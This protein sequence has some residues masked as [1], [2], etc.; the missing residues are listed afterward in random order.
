MIFIIGILNVQRCNRF[1][2]LCNLAY[3]KNKYIEEHFSQNINNLETH[4]LVLSHCK[5]QPQFYS[6]EKEGQMYVCDCD[7]DNK[8]SIVF[9][10]TK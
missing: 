1:A 9:R 4:Y 7:Y 2:K 6:G 5:N 10:C 3:M 8:L